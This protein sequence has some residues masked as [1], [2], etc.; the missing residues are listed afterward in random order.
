MIEVMMSTTEDDLNVEK[1]IDG[2][3]GAFEALFQKYRNPLFGYLYYMLQER[4]AA[5][6]VFQDT[7]LRIIENISRYRYEDKFPQFLYRVAGN[8]ALDLMRKR[9]KGREI[10]MSGEG[11][12]SLLDRNLITDLRQSP[13]AVTER[14]VLCE[15]L[16]GGIRAL[17][18][19]QRQVFLLRHYLDMPFKE[20]ARVIGCSLNTA[21][22]RMHYAFRN[23][24]KY[25]DEHENRTPSPGSPCGKTI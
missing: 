15:E 14:N 23:M 2:D 5:E 22:G 16:I 25:L 9:K 12:K 17:P 4:Q 13:E 11:E 3:E 8:G 6:D 19:D 10:P 20:V 21:L 24:R 18:A 7:W 1:F